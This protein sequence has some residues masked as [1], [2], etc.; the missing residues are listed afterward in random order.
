[1][2]PLDASR[3]H[4]EQASIFKQGPIL[5]VSFLCQAQEQIQVAADRVIDGLIADY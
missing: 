1:M 2:E 4:D 3:V 5:V